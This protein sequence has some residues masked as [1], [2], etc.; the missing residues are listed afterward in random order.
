MAKIGVMIDCDYCEKPTLDWSNVDYHCE[1]GT[2]CIYPQDDVS[3][4]LEDHLAE[5]EGK[6]A[7]MEVQEWEHGEFC[8]NCLSEVVLTVRVSRKDPKQKDED[9]SAPGWEGGFADNH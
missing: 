6:Q 2:L 1:S 4:L 7:G 3:P 5:V 9:Y 8:H